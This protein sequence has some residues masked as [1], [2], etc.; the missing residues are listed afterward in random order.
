VVLL[1]AVSWAG[2]VDG[3]GRK[4]GF[5]DQ[6]LEDRAPRLSAR[7][8]K[9]IVTALLDSEKKTGTDAFLLL[10]VIEEESQYDPSARSRKGAWG[11][12]QLQP[13]TA[14]GVAAREGIAW[15]GRRDL[16]DSA[17]NVRLGAAYLAELKEQFG[18]W[19]RA[20]GAYNAGPT[21]I[22][23]IERR[24]GRIPT[25]YSSRVLRRH[26]RIA[27]AFGKNEP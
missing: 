10:A 17:R 11:L 7:S 9:V 6:W 15:S 3:T 5:L 16:E 20:L 4:A 12:M 24:G 25:R 21:R 18:S 13:A 22:R 27:E 8:R 23:R 14:R 2:C 26:Q 19:E 1:A